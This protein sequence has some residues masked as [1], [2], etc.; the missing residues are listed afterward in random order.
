MAALDPPEKAQHRTSHHLREKQNSE[1]NRDRPSLKIASQ[2][3]RKLTSKIHSL[4]LHR[5]FFTPS[6]QMSGAFTR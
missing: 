6:I 2:Q 4:S 5:G 1:E 3:F